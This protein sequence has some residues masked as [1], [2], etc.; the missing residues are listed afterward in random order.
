MLM[1][2]RRSFQQNYFLCADNSE[3]F[4]LYA[5]LGAS[6]GAILLLLLVT[7]RLWRLH[8]N[9]RRRTRTEHTCPF[10]QRQPSDFAPETTLCMTSPIDEFPVPPPPTLSSTGSRTAAMT[11]MT[12]VSCD[13]LFD[14]IRH[15]PSDVDLDEINGYSRTE[16]S[17]SL[18]VTPALSAS[19]RPVLHFDE[20]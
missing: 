15:T 3:L 6:L 18:L 2:Y 14:R 1:L 20:D 16:H 12:S 19:S 10:F 4:I 9:H 13:L 8:R 17:R 11:S 5:S 7:G